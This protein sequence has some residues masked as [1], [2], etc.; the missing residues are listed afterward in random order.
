MFNYTV[1][2]ISP[3]DNLY[4]TYDNYS[5]HG[6]TRFG[7]VVF[8]KQILKSDVQLCI[9]MYCN[10]RHAEVM[11]TIQIST[12]TAFMNWIIAIGICSA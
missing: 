6:S 3:E 9:C 10:F 5:M 12:A 2:C 7:D 1:F 4:R 8:S 11:E